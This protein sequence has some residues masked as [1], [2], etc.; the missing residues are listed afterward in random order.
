[1]IIHDGSVAQANLQG[2]ANTSHGKT[3]HPK[4]HAGS[5]IYRSRIGRPKE[6]GPIVLQG[7]RGWAAGA[8][9][10]THAGQLVHSVGCPRTCSVP[11]PDCNVCKGEKRPVCK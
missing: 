10:V 4:A 5:W 8:L 7:T 6:S 3:A 9:S 1:M 2:A 11:S